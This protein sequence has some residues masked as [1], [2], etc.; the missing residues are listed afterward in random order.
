MTGTL[1]PPAPRASRRIAAPRPAAGRAARS[2]SAGLDARLR[3]L[4]AFLREPL[5][6]GALWPSSSALSRLVLA[7]CDFQPGDTVVELGPG[8]GAFTELI[9]DRLQER[10]RFLALEINPASVALLRG[11]FPRCHV[12]HDSAENLARH[13]GRRRAACIVSGL[14]WGNMLPRTQNRILREI[15]RALAPGGHFVTFAYL[16][17]LWFPTSLRFRRRL[18]RNFARVETS[19]IVWRNLP[20]ALVYRCW[21]G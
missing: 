19:P 9:L 12:I 13:V 4:G 7:S 14:A 5:T 11:R 10:G 16:H 18:F 1:E 3:F 6:V 8:T 15:L 21:Q 17:A 20:P 2:A